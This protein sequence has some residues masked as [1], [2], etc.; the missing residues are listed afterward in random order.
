M[1]CIS[2]YT[3]VAV[4]VSPSEVMDFSSIFSFFSSSRGG[5]SLSCL[6]SGLANLEKEEGREDPQLQHVSRSPNP[7]SVSALL[8][9]LCVL[10]HM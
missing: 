9:H 10:N 6:F 5:F 1:V 7:R 4:L 3:L 2:M 8:I